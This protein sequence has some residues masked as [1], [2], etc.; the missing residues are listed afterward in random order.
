M[1]SNYSSY[2]TSCINF[3]VG[4]AQV[5]ANTLAWPLADYSY[6]NARDDVDGETPKL[7]RCMSGL[8]PEHGGRNNGVLGGWYFNGVQIPNTYCRHIIQPVPASGIAGVVNMHQCRQF[9]TAVEGVYTCI[10]RNSSWMYQSVRL[11]VYY[12]GRGE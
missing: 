1:Q 5:H 4:I 2:T 7:A 8:G 9:S 12:R 6:I 10:M 3:T 11:G